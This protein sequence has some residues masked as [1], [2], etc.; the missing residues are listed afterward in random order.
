MS[1]KIYIVQGVIPW[2]GTYP[3]LALTNED[4]AQEVLRR[5]AQERKVSHKKGA[6]NIPRSKWRWNKLSGNDDMEYQELLLY[7]HLDELIEDL[8]DK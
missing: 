2:E 3:I 8:I 5:A 6:K 1:Q 4:H 7:A